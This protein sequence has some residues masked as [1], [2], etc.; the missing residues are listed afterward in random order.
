MQVIHLG[1]QG[2]TRSGGG[3]RDRDDK[4]T[5]NG[6]VTELSPLWATGVLGESGD[7]TVGGITSPQCAEEGGVS[8][9]PT[10][11]VTP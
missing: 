6:G 5:P 11:P 9:H 10:P 3:Q 4:E 7:R 2:D 8:I 1:G